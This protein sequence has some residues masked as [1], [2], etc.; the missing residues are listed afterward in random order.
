M[1]FIL[2]AR[3]TFTVPQQGFATN[4]AIATW[5]IDLNFSISIWRYCND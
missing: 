5:K 2:Y 4:L 1:N 3:K